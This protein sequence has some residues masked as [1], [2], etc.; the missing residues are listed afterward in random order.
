MTKYKKSGHI[1]YEN[2][3]QKYSDSFI[4]LTKSIIKAYL[5]NSSYPRKQKQKSSLLKMNRTL[6]IGINCFDE[7][8]SKMKVLKY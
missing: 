1:L 3:F 7:E 6:S 4:I 8:L 2:S 5:I